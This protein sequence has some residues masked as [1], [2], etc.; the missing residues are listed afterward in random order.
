MK[1]GEYFTAY[2][3]GGIALD[4]STS[5][6][7]NRLGKFY[8]RLLTQDSSVACDSARLN[9]GFYDFLLQSAPTISGKTCALEVAM[10]QFEQSRR[11]I[12]GGNTFAIYSVLLLDD[13]Y[14]RK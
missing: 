5:I 13:I 3:T 1:E 6:C 7:V 14:A 12:F 8:L 11:D 9:R 10:T 2:D 4:L